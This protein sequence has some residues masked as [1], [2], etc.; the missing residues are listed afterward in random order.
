M[1]K[2]TVLVFA[3]HPDDEIIGVGGTIAKYS[4]EGKDVIVIIF[5]DGSMSN[6]WLKH[7]VLVADR[8][9]DAKEIGIFMG[10][11]ETIFLGLKDSKLQDYTNDHNV[12]EVLKKIIIKYHPKKIF[13]HSQ[14]DPHPDHRAVH[15]IGMKAIVD[16]DKNQQIPVY[17][18]EVWNALPERQPALY[19]DITETFQKKVQAMKKFKSE[20]LSIYTLLIPVYVRAILAGFHHKGKYAE[21]FYKVR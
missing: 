7:E 5:S 19:V 17:V 21:K 3:A 1:N 11:K 8:K 16:V 4:Q 15:E 14:H 20:K 18:F 9:K 6:P 12:R 10:C 13:I 2:E